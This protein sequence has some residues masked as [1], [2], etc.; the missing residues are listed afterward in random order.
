MPLLATGWEGGSLAY[1]QARGWTPSGA[2]STLDIEDRYV[3]RDENGYGGDFSMFVRNGI[4]SPVF[5]SPRWFHAWIFTTDPLFTTLPI[6]FRALGSA[7]ITIRIE[8]SGQIQ[9]R[10]G[11]TG[12][13]TL[14]TSGTNLDMSIGHWFA[15]ECLVADTAGTVK[16]YIDGSSST[17]VEF[18]GDTAA[19]G[20][21]F[22]DQFSFSDVS[23]VEGFIDDIIIT[24]SSEGQQTESFERRVVLV[25]DTAAGLTP[26][27]GTQNFQNVIAYDTA[28]YNKGTTATTQDLYGAQGNLALGVIDFVQ[29]EAVAAHQNDFEMQTALKSGAT[30]VYGTLGTGT[31]TYR[32]VPTTLYTTDP[33]TSGAWTAAAVNALQA[34]VRTGP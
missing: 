17:F 27:T 29:V 19:T 31:A 6:I 30:T 22:W 23:G 21:F 34:G 20:D 12:G 5:S 25:S 26:S 7:Q 13:V 28:T 10:R 18:T 24:T 14:A 33:N 32:N 1:Y 2:S 11:G 15:I 4:I 9:I 8:S 16:V 3:H